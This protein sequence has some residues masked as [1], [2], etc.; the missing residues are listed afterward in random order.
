MNINPNYWLKSVMAKAA[1]VPTSLDGSYTSTAKI[2][3][4]S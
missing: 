3:L 4:L 1:M 2:K